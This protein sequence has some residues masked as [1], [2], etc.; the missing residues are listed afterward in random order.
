MASTM[1]N[2]SAYAESEM[3]SVLHSAKWNFTAKQFHAALAA[4]HPSEGRIS[5]KKAAFRL[6]FLVEMGG[7]E[8]PSESTLTGTSPGAG[9]HLYSLTRA[10]A[11][12]LTGSVA[13]LCVVRSKLCA[14]T[15]TTDRRSV[16]GRGPPEGN[17][18]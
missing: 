13:S 6:L 5:L 12:M 10:Q 16:S 11:V 14:L 18:R 8:P 7:V 4:F 9:G 15:G 1:A 2:F 17:A 3:K